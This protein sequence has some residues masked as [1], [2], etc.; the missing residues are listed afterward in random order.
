MTNG[1]DSTGVA[2]CG[3]GDSAAAR[4]GSR[5]NKAAISAARVIVSL[6]V[7]AAHVQRPF[8]YATSS[9]SRE[10]KV[11]SGS[12]KAAAAMHGCTWSGTQSATR[13]A[14]SGLVMCRAG[15]GPGAGS[16][17]DG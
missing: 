10:Q 2:V 3:R 11:L 17:S 12:S 7:D 15:A 13:V 8:N 16:E 5:R 14:A 9:V 6:L 4:A 1:A